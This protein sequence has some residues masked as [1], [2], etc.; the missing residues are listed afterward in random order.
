MPVLGKKGFQ[1]GF[2]MPKAKSP[3]KENRSV[4]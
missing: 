4:A 2:I 3:A 1:Q